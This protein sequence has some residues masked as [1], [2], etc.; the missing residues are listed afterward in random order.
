MPPKIIK[1]SAALAKVIGQPE[2]TRPQALKQIW[3]YIK[4]HNLQ[5]PLNKREVLN[6]PNLKDVFEGK[7]KVHMF[8]VRRSPFRARTHCL[9]LFHLISFRP[10]SSPFI[11]PRRLTGR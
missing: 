7:D 4:Q 10:I 3:V 11:V 5:N 2:I 8:E 6:D 1:V 9:D